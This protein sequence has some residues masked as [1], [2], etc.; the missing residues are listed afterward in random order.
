MT[1]SMIVSKYDSDTKIRDN[2]EFDYYTVST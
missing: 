1:L 2:S